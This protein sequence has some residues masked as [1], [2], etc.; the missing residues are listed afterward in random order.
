MANPLPNEQELFSKIRAERIRVSDAVWDL[1][2]QHIGDDLTAINLICSY[3]ASNNEGVPPEEAKKILTY[4][5]HIKN[6]LNQVTLASSDEFLFPSVE[7]QM[8]L[9]PVIRHML[10]HYIGNDTYMIN[11][12]LYDTI[13]PVA[14][15]PLTPDLAG[16]VLSHAK[17]IRDFL[18]R[19]REATTS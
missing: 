3:Y 13:D 7:S 15:R 8:P 4:T 19:L 12:V 5:R 14:P 2:Y 6:I 11:L 18:E 16:M 1:I 10:T 17:C 9:H